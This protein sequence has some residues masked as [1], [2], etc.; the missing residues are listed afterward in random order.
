MIRFSCKCGHPFEL[1]DDAAGSDVQ[2][3]NCGL[4][5]GVP[6]MS[7]KGRLA[8][9][10]TYDLDAP[11]VPLDE[12]RVSTFAYVYAKAKVDADGNE[13]DLRNDPNEPID[14]SEFQL[15]EEAVHAN[16]PRYDPET[17]ERIT[18][19][20]LVGEEHEQ[21]RVDPA[22]VP[23]AKPVIT[24]ATAGSLRP[25][26]AG[27]VLLDLCQ[28]LN[29]VVMF[30]VFFIHLAIG[31]FTFF[32]ALG[33]FIIA[34]A[35][36]AAIVTVLSHYGNTIDDIAT[37]GLDELPRPLRDLRLYEDIW[38]P[39]VGVCGALLFSYAPAWIA[40]SSIQSDVAAFA[41][42]LPL[43]LAGTFALPAL[44]LTLLTSGSYSNLRPDR[45]LGV[46]RTCGSR[47]F[48]VSFLFVLAIIP[49]LWAM[50]GITVGAIRR[51]EGRIDL[52]LWVTNPIL[53]TAL[54]VTGIFLMHLFCWHVGLLHRLNHGSFPWVG[55]YHVRKTHDPVP[56]KR[57][58]YVQPSPTGPVRPLPPISADDSS[59]QAG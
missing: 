5:V 9:D 23:F 10:G 14:A 17:G 22:T 44:L 7:D 52:P 2:C 3:T 41:I 13:I 18:A 29:G 24:Y 51:A 50:G 6:F 16:K 34:P 1:A 15:A 42:G 39:L 46:I 53:I 47:Y 28:P 57:P 11:P 26:S 30:F 37:E 38:M 58:R 8:E 20:P 54:F 43:A 32:A 56:R 31:F 33:I 4:L 59:G 12:D 49:Y 48:V 45:V 40:L 25:R 21:K 35:I 36:L 55:R 27:H 19:I